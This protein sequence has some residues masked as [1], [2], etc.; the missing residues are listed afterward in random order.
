MLL[1]WRNTLVVVTNLTK[2]PVTTGYGLVKLYHTPA[3]VVAGNYPNNTSS[4]YTSVKA[5][6]YALPASS[7]KFWICISVTGNSE[8]R[9]AYH[10]SPIPSKVCWYPFP[11]MGFD[12]S[13]ASPNVDDYWA[14]L[15]WTSVN[16]LDLSS[17]PEVVESHFKNPTSKFYPENW[18]I[19]MVLQLFSS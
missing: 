16:S 9:S 13:Q 8:G 17:I 2:E 18:S 4:R 1:K 5:I 6:L 15:N 11:V 3:S 7:A 10:D 19:K 14:L 12:A